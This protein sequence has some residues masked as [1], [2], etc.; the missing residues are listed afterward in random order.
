MLLHEEW[1][2]RHGSDE[3]GAYYAQLTG[4]QQ[5]GSGPGR[6]SYEMVRRGMMATLAREDARVRV[7]R[8]PS[9]PAAAV[10]SAAPPLAANRAWLGAALEAS[11]LPVL[12]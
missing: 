4:L 10:A 12:R 5:L 2:L 6:W 8:Q 11:R 1:H 9:P 7:T 3:R